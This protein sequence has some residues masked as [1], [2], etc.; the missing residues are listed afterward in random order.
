MNHTFEYIPYISRRNGHI[1]SEE[2]L[3]LL[4]KYSCS[5]SIAYRRVGFALFNLEIG[6]GSGEFILQE[7]IKNPGAFYYGCEVYNPGIV[8]LV[9]NLESKNIDNVCVYKG[10]AREFLLGAPDMFFENIYVLFPDPWPKK[11]HHKRRLINANFLQFIAKKFRSG[12][13]I[14][15]DHD[16]YAKSILH[17]VSQ[18]DSYV[19]ERL[20]MTRDKIFGTKFETKAMSRDSSILSLILKH[21]S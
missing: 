6:F 2:N 5:S 12:L 19:I 7:A 18:C 21:R 3:A 13:H 17:E 20:E 14:A 1:K 11:K 10:D 16:G 15:T 8:K 4:D 9:R